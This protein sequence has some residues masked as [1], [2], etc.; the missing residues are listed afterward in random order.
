ML[1]E[2]NGNSKCLT[3]I[4]THKNNEYADWSVRL[5]VYLGAGIRAWAAMSK[6]S[7]MKEQTKLELNISSLIWENWRGRTNMS[8]Y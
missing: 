8:T 7:M 5:S 6:R 1:F 3:S 4:D 2:H